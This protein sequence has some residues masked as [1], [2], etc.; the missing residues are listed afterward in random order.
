MMA[1]VF[2]FLNPKAGGQ[3]QNPGGQR[4]YLEIPP[5][6]LRILQMPYPPSGQSPMSFMQDPHPQP[7]P[8]QTVEQ[9]MGSVCLADNLW[10][11]LGRL[12]L[13]GTPCTVTD[14]R[15]S[16]HSGAVIEGTPKSNICAA[17]GLWGRLSEG[18]AVGT[19]CALTDESRIHLGRIV[20]NSALAIAVA[21]GMQ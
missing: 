5:S 10:G 13:V 11:Y 3:F 15:G 2:G 17:D 12:Y 4:L 7:S 19:Q 18:Y 20:L 8:L 1:A 21:G 6:S 14:V 16:L 9:P